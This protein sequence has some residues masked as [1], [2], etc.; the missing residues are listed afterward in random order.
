MLPLELF[1]LLIDGETTR[2]LVDQEKETT[3]DRQGLEEVV[4]A[5]VHK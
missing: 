5:K 3:N 2:S 4:P 1:L